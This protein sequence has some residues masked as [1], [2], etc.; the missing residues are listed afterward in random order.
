MIMAIYVVVCSFCFGLVI[1]SFL[2][3]VIYRVPRELSIVNPPS[4]CPLCHRPIRAWENIPLFSYLIVLKG[5]CAGCGERI[6]LQYPLIELFTGL[7]FATVA[8]RFGFSFQMIVYLIFSA[9][10][11]ALSVIDLKTYLLP[12]SIVLPGLIAA[13][14]LAVATLYKPFQIFWPVSP[15]EA[16]WGMVAGGI[17]LLVLAWVYQKLTKREGMGGGDIKLMFFVGALLG[18]WNAFLTIFIGSLTGSIIGVLYLRLSSMQ[19][20][21]QIPFGPFLSLGAWITMMWGHE[22]IRGYLQFLGLS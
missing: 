16:F 20:H 18:P 14:A 2:N 21:T 19:R 15:T 12:D 6:S 10:L 3:V 22:L 8:W 13:C 4:S 11:I 9:M 17:P 1:G 7:V 5:K